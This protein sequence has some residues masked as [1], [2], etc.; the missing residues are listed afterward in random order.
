[1]FTFVGVHNTLC[2]AA[3]QHSGNEEQKE[4]MLRG[5]CN[6]DKIGAFGLTEPTTEV[7]RFFSKLMSN[8]LEEDTFSMGLKDGS[9]TELLLTTL[10]CGRAT[11]LTR[12]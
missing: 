5:L 8:Q 12:S 6:F 10:W 2:A 4:R 1:M 3:I 11:W 7:T 9:E